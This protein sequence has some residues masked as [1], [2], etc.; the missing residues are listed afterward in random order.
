MKW[1][2]RYTIKVALSFTLTSRFTAVG[3]QLNASVQGSVLIS[4]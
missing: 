2:Q 1:A 3:S 4:L